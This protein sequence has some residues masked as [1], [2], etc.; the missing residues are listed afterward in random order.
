MCFLEYTSVYVF[1]GLAYGTLEVLW[2][3]YTHWTMLLAGGFCCCVVHWLSTTL[4]EPLWKKR[5]MSAAVATCIEFVVGCVVNLRLGWN[6]W[7]YSGLPLNLYGQIC[8]L[9]SLFWLLLSVPAVPLFM[10]LRRYVF[11]RERRDS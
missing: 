11:V 9:F 5:I 3:G 6:V 7:H 4:R 2:R 10:F 1:G 8:P